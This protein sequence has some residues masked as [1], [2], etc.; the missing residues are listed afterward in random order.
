MFYRRGQEHQ[1]EQ[2]PI[3]VAFAIIVYKVQGIT[4][5][6]AV[7]DITIRE[8]TTRL[9]YIAVSRVKNINTLIFKKLFDFSL[10]TTTLRSVGLVRDADV[11]RRAPKR[12]M[13]KGNSTDKD[14]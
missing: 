3:Y 6:K 12:I 4:L 10:F 7:I 9:R 2:F 14:T 1:R 13:P 8:F 5:E 11:K